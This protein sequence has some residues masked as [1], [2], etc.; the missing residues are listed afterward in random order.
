MSAEVP[1]TLLRQRITA[2][3]TSHQRLHYA[4]LEWSGGYMRPHRPLLLPQAH[5]G[6]RV[7]ARLASSGHCVA[8]VSPSGAASSTRQSSCAPALQ[9]RCAQS[10]SGD[11]VTRTV[12]YARQLT[13]FGLS[14]PASTD[15][16]V[17]SR[18]LPLGSAQAKREG[19]SEQKSCR[20]PVSPCG[21]VFTLGE[22]Q[23][24][25]VS[26]TR[27]YTKP[28]CHWTPQRAPLG[29]LCYLDRDDSDLDPVGQSPRIVNPLPGL[30]AP[31]Q[32]AAYRC[33]L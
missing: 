9:W 13:I 6:S 20:P 23:S 25:Q 10:Q 31:R 4:T 1:T 17:D 14:V 32:L 12:A 18:P 29:P 24:R 33:R 26:R 16:A 27:L 15:V 19:S 21:F 3:R 8:T 2:G 5:E 30:P 22:S 7:N 28:R 11:R